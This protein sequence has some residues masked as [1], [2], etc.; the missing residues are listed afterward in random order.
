[1]NPTMPSMAGV[2]VALAYFALVAYL[3]KI[4][5]QHHRL[6]GVIGALIGLL[7]VLPAILYALNFTVEAAA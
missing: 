4:L 7:G 2:L 3:V 1:M 6:P 5:K